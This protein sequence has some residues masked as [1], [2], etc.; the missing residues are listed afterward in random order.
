MIL[1][2]PRLMTVG[3]TQMEHRKGSNDNIKMKGHKGH[4]W[5]VRL[6]IEKGVEKESVM[7][8]MDVGCEYKALI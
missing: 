1:P 4:P 6:L 7:R 2:V 3:F 8:T 5:H